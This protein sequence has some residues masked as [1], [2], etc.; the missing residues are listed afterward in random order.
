M[1]T[2][3]DL[4][5]ADL[6]RSWESNHQNIKTFLDY[7]IGYQ[8]CPGECGRPE[9]EMTG[10]GRATVSWGAPSAVGTSAI[11]AYRLEVAYEDKPSKWIKLG[12]SPNCHM[13]VCGLEDGGLWLRVSASNIH[14]YGPPRQSPMYY[15]RPDPSPPICVTNL[16]CRPYGNHL[17]LA[18]QITGYPI[19]DARWSRGQ[20][21]IEDV[22]RIM[23]ERDDD[24]YRL[25][26][27]DATK[28]DNGLYCL[29][30]VNSEGR[31]TCYCFVSVETK[32]DLTGID[33]SIYRRPVDVEKAPEFTLPLRDRVVDV[34]STVMLSCYV[35]GN[36]KPSVTWKNNND[37]LLSTSG[38]VTI[39]SDGH[40]HSIE[41]EKVKPED[42]GEYSCIAENS[43][44]YVSTSCCLNIE[45]PIEPP[46]FLH[47]LEETKEVSEGSTM[48]LS[49]MVLI[50][51][52]RPTITWSR[53]G[54]ELRPRKER[55]MTYSADGT[56]ELCIA[57]LMVSD[58]AVYTCTA[59]TPAGS[60][61]TSCTVHVIRRPASPSKEKYSCIPYSKKPLFVMKPCCTDVVEGDTV[62]FRV[63]VVG[64]PNPRVIWYR[65]NLKVEYFREKDQFLIGNDGSDHWLEVRRCKLY[66]SGHYLAQA[67]N[68][69]GY[70][71]AR[72][73]LQVFAQD[74]GRHLL[75]T[76]DTKLAKV[77][78]LPLI[79][80]PLGDI[81]CSS[82]SSVTLECRIKGDPQPDVIWTKEG[83]VFRQGERYT[84]GES[85]GLVL[86]G[87]NPHHQG[88]YK[89]EAYNPLGRA[90]TSAYLTVQDNQD[91]DQHMN[92]VSPCVTREATNPEVL[93]LRGK[94]GSEARFLTV[95]H[96][97]VVL[98]GDPVRLICSGA[99]YPL[100]SATW[101]KDSE[102]INSPR[103]KITESGDLFSL[104]IEETRLEDAG[105]YSV[106]LENKKGRVEASATI[107]VISHRRESIK[108]VSKDQFSR[109]YKDKRDNGRERD[110]QHNDQHTPIQE[111]TASEGS[112]FTLSCHIGSP[113]SAMWYKD[114]EPIKE[115]GDREISWEEDGL[116]CLRLGPLVPSD[117]GLYS[118]CLSQDWGL[119]QGLVRLS[120]TP[121]AHQEIRPPIFTKGLPPEINA[122]EGQSVSISATISGEEPLKIVWSKGESEEIPNCEDMSHVQLGN[123]EIALRIVD[124][125]VEDS[126]LYTC[127]VY[128]KHGMAQSHT[129]LV[130]KEESANQGSEVPARILRPPNDCI[131]LR[132][133]KAELSARFAGKPEPTLMWSKGGVELSNGKRLTIHT[134][135]DIG[136]TKLIIDPVEA[137]DSGKYVLTV[138]N[139]LAT[140]YHFASLS[141]EGVPDPPANRP[142]AEL[143]SP[144][145]SVTWS[146]PHYDGGSMITGYSL[147]VSGEDN[148]WSTVA[149]KCHS[150][151]H[152]VYNL[153]K[154][155]AFK[156]RVRSHNIHGP[157][158][159]S[160]ESQAVSLIDIKKPDFW[161][162]VQFEDGSSF[163]EKYCRL[164]ELGK[165]RYGTVHRIKEHNRGLE[166]AAKTVRCIKKEDRDK[167]AQEVDIMNCLRHPKL[168]QLIAAYSNPRE[169][170]LVLEYISGGE[171]FERVVADDFTL[172]EKDCILFMRQICEGVKYMHSRSIVHL[173]LKP[174]N[175]MCTTRDSH[176]IKLI[177]FGLAQKL[178]GDIPVRVLFGTPEF[179]APEIIS[180]EP[181]GVQT[182]MWSVGVICY[183]L[184][185]GLS[186]FMG[187]NDAETFANITRADF[188][189]EDEAFDSISQTAKEFITEL[190]IK[191]KEKR[192]TAE[193]CLAHKWMTQEY[194]EMSQIKLST[195]KLKK[196]IIRRK[197]QKTGNAIR[198]L[199]R[200]ANLS[201]ASRRGSQVAM[202]KAGSDSNKKGQQ[203]SERSDS[204]FSD[205][206][207][208]GSLSTPPRHLLQK[209]LISE[210]IK[211]NNKSLKQK[212]E[213]G[214]KAKNGI[215]G[216]KKSES[217]KKPLHTTSMN[218]NVQKAFAFWN[219]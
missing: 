6:R 211:D 194:T 116:S 27:C 49:A 12:L 148:I 173:D 85:S 108:M 159:P 210:E 24:I 33:D 206:S 186:P 112:T 209:Y 69:H 179:I 99:G 117:T 65:D 105:R 86:T 10:R 140:V 55:V 74:E 204:G 133:N 34:F 195:D 127:T 188:D 47:K 191:R 160:L 169:I 137:D 37:T 187:E 100:P 201:A 146:S 3:E 20:E 32:P 36:P 215:E 203:C 64:D 141:V 170:I 54:V 39:L 9:L 75:R 163:L 183:V 19:P 189:F 171:L 176:D 147:E 199:G 121:L 155:K 95:P 83:K 158:E 143:N 96:D 126:G 135:N 22:G 72:F 219:R 153:E 124:P 79:T 57:Y 166:Y 200:M 8:E 214:A 58:T 103:L 13:D 63:Q 162:A 145:I 164:E 144:G 5:I 14:G 50:S 41:I 125:F 43:Q 15:I 94:R 2:G 154:N 44:G 205:C 136:E 7:L 149:E 193:E 217:A 35:T 208:A 152:T 56:V 130:V 92:H 213:D 30:A 62:K 84:E 97:R 45:G 71:N 46:E 202:T 178:S 142:V 109:R 190:L 91:Q 29:E 157:S 182:D 115:E 104:E 174:E 60:A 167:A 134:D 131:A 110:A 70:A 82:G 67:T 122:Q 77:H 128:N 1:V 80:R 25:T 151:S 175:I 23:V 168:L 123:G 106:T 51:P 180:Y 52:L 114:G 165:G 31:A 198:A 73:S 81:E 111:C 21:D 102:K 184:L 177:D 172:T 17:V 18:C 48:R 40:Y 138:Y 90:S 53:D 68:S 88:L 118:C 4:A 216:L 212:K 28:D 87:I 192:L 66:F 16:E 197:W 161:K 38:N 218:E 59:T 101:Y 207:T 89:C 11:V 129:R 113:S 185:S 26:I 61:T 42:C 196:F 150:L 119:A 98:A 139:H 181:I 120:V 156:F 78:S 107:Q 132:G 76:V 93:G